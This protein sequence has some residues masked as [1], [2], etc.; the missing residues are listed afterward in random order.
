ML[1]FAF[2]NLGLCVI[3]VRALVGTVLGFLWAGEKEGEEVESDR[4]GCSL[5]SPRDTSDGPVA[6]FPHHGS[7]LTFSVNSRSLFLSLLSRLERTP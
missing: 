3:F 5:K 7:L 6:D 4:I 2:P 1:S